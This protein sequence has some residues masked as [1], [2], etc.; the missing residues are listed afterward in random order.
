MNIAK[1]AESSLQ[2]KEGVRILESKLENDGLIKTFFHTSDTI[3]NQDGYF[4]LYNFNNDPK[5]EFVVQIKTCKEI[6]KNDKGV[7]YYDID[8]KFINYV[9]TQVCESPAI[10]FVVDMKSKIVFWRYLSKEFLEANDFTNNEQKTARLFFTCFDVV[11]DVENVFVLQ[12]KTIIAERKIKRSDIASEDVFEYQKAF[13]RINNLFDIDFCKLKEVVYSN[14]WKFG[15]GYNKTKI[16]SKTYKQIQAERKKYNIG[17]APYTTTF[18]VYQ[19][20]KGEDKSAFHNIKAAWIGDEKARE[21]MA[22]L[23]I[24]SIAGT[25]AIS[26]T[27]EEAANEWL[28]RTIRNLIKIKAPFVKFMPDEVLHEIAFKFLDGLAAIDTKYAKQDYYWVYHA[29]E[30]SLQELTE[31]VTQKYPRQNYRDTNTAV[32]H[33]ALQELHTRKI[34]TIKRVWQHKD[35]SK[36]WDWHGTHIWGFLKETL[37]ENFEKLYVSLPKMYEITLKNL[38]K[39]NYQKY[40]HKGKYWIVLELSS[41]DGYQNT[42]IRYLLDKSEPFAVECVDTRTYDKVNNDLTDK[43]SIVWASGASRADFAKGTPLFNSLLAMLYKEICS[44][45][46]FK[47]ER[48]QE[49]ECDLAW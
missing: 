3:P 44:I 49:I 26:K 7:Y 48:I 40:L 15:I 6:K 47:Y 25:N 45:Q 34:E 28:E 36:F 12:L 35:K 13:D 10:I 4:T 31:M 11:E 43:N 5:K 23:G 2:E 19:V 1:K 24:E 20:L 18:G 37:Q 38:I 21:E 33:F 9:A 41:L 8:T 16:D 14:T 22:A 39:N 32:L 30:I 27:I 42:N 29:D 17:T 46:N